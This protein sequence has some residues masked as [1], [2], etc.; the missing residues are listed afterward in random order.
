MYLDK[1]AILFYWGF[2]YVHFV[3]IV[4]IVNKMYLLYRENF[5]YLLTKFDTIVSQS[6]T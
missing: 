5:N 6:S 2:N 4:S 3:S 1:F